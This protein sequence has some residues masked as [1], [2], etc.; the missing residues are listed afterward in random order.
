MSQAMAGSRARPTMSVY[1]PIRATCCVCVLAFVAAPSF[2]EVPRLNSDTQALHT[3]YLDFDGHFEPKS[4]HFCPP[5][6]NATPEGWPVDVSVSDI[7]RTISGN[8]VRAIWQ[9]VAEDFAPFNAK[10]TTDPVYEPRF[11]SANALRVAIGGLSLDPLGVAPSG[12]EDL[13]ANPPYLN[14]RIA[15]VAVVNLVDPRSVRP[16]E[17]AAKISHE[18]GHLYGLAHH[19]AQPTTLFDRWIVARLGAAS[20]YIWRNG[21]NEFGRHQ[22][23]LAQLAWLLG[24][25]VDEANPTAL[26]RAERTTTAGTELSGFYAHATLT[27]EGDID[28]FELTVPNVSTLTFQVHGGIW[29]NPFSA[30]TGSEPNLRYHLE[31]RSRNGNVKIACPAQLPFVINASTTGTLWSGDCTQPP[32]LVIGATYRVRVYRDARDVLP[33]NVGRYTVTVDVPAPAL[34]Q[35]AR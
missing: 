34:P 3:I 31:V 16:R 10:V 20:R 26:V 28:D 8:D 19:T 5:P 18:A 12:C 7:S 17:E 1:E 9:A 6:L 35:P 22:D 30:Q 15:N 2:G 13:L 25:R 23:D 29:A 21:E 33:G 4:K 24:A 14:P 27:T 32:N 11:E